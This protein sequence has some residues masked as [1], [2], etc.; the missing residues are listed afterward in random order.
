M[1]DVIRKCARLGLYRLA[2]LQ[3]QNAFMAIRH[4]S[5]KTFSQP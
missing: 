3:K 2:I 5:N 1:L 4:R